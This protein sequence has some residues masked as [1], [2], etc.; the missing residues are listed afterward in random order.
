M[1][2]FS[3][4]REQ[5]ESL[6]GVP[7]TSSSDLTNLGESASNSDCPL[8]FPCKAEDR[9]WASSSY[10]RDL[11]VERHSSTIPG[12]TKKQE[13][14]RSEDTEFAAE[15]TSLP[16]ATP[17]KSEPSNVFSRVQPESYQTVWTTPTPTAE[18]IMKEDS[19]ATT[20]YAAPESMPAKDL[21]RNL[22]EAL[23]STK[24]K[25]VFARAANLT[26]EAI[27]L[28]GMIF[29]DASISSFG[30]AA[31]DR[32]DE[33]A[34]GGF[35]TNIVRDFTT[36][37]S[38][39][40]A[41]YEDPGTGLLVNTQSI[42]IHKDLDT[43]VG[44]C[45]ILG[46][47]TRSRS[48]ILGHAPEPNHESFSEGMLRALLKKYPHG[49]VYNFHSDG[50]VSSSDFEGVMT[51]NSIDFKGRVPTE[52][53]K[54][55]TRRQR[56]SKE[57][58]AESIRRALPEARSVL[59]YPLWDSQ[60]ER[61]FAGG[62]MWSTSP[63]RVLDPVEDLTYM[64]SF[65]NSIM[66]EI[67]RISAMLSSQ[68]KNDFVSSISHEL[69]SP[70]HGILAS[71]ELLQETKMMDIQEDMINTI[72]SCGKTLLD[73][74]NHVL[75][76]SKVNKKLK[77]RHAKRS[78]RK[79]LHVKPRTTAEER[80]VTRYED[81]EDVSMLTEEVVESVSAGSSFGTRLQMSSKND[82]LPDIESQVSIIID[83]DSRTNHMF[84][85]DAGAWRRILM[86]LFGNALK[87]VC[88]TCA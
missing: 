33:R 40:E 65:S 75:D 56:M 27:Q 24:I 70:L 15:N 49:K 2:A 87:Y 54:S 66:A 29:Y 53:Q 22:Q 11:D 20:D 84:E 78:T 43:K 5:A 42:N 82:T 31:K 76:F 28:D 7:E 68:M 9:Y 44:G 25:D 32:V 67:A 51:R 59:F 50:A 37:G 23:L 63:Y 6:F 36:S 26:R 83:E 74:I 57:K 69:R 72:E 81:L 19:G 77:G 13:A 18:D 39:E 46:F 52:K 88:K 10:T 8:M 17:A 79:A 62:F 64:V 58:E 30:A 60:R 45:N 80:D 21:G 55:R 3:S 41:R 14:A 86:N 48:T 4:V 38:E 47:S 16:L 35:R 61:W 71:V 34:P 85:I 1:S 12:E 73:T